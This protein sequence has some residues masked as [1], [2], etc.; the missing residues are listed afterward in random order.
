MR[1]F[2]PWFAILAGVVVIGCAS[3]KTTTAQRDA[4]D[5]FSY[6]R[7]PPATINNTPFERILAPLDFS[8]AVIRRSSQIDILT[9]VVTESPPGVF[10]AKIDSGGTPFT[11]GDLLAWEWQGTGTDFRGNQRGIRDRH[12]RTVVHMGAL[13]NVRPEKVGRDGRASE[14]C[15]RFQPLSPPQ[16]PPQVPN[17][18]TVVTLESDYVRLSTSSILVPAGEGF[19]KPYPTAA[20]LHVCGDKYPPGECSKANGVVAR[21]TDFSGKSQSICTR[22]FNYCPCPKGTVCE[23]PQLPP[24]PSACI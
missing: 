1:R 8:A 3:I 6:Y 14:V 23:A 21:W 13:L 4:L 10:V 15:F 12:Y 11:S 19:V 2:T 9:G 7:T 5:G 20:P 18:A 24:V 16:D 17:S 22:V